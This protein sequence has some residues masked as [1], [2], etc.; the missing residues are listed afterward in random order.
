MRPLTT[1]TIMLLVEAHF[2]VMLRSGNNTTLSNRKAWQCR[3]LHGYIFIIHAVS[4][5]RTSLF[6][7]VNL[8]SNAKTKLPQRFCFT[9]S[10]SYLYI[11]WNVMF[12]AWLWPYSNKRQINIQSKLYHTYKYPSKYVLDIFL[13][14]FKYAVWL[15]KT[16]N[17]CE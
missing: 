10:R 15:T 17:L 9:Q 6:V 3:P 1:M 2:T 12:N 11:F 14:N 8:C 4:K 16:W 5:S 13:A 7:K